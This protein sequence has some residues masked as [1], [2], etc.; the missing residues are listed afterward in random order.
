VVV[1]FLLVREMWWWGVGSVMG[2]WAG[3]LIGEDELAAIF[4]S[5]SLIL[6]SEFCVFV[7]VDG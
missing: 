3:M 4:A 1:L 2:L 7:A 5:L 6:C